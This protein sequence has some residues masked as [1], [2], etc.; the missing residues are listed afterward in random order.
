MSESDNTPEEKQSRKKTACKSEPDYVECDA[1]R[2]SP[3]CSPVKVGDHTYDFTGKMV[4]RRHYFKRGE[5]IFK[6]GEKAELI[7]A[8]SA[9]SL[10]LIAHVKD[11]N[12]VIDF[13]IPGE[14]IDVCSLNEGRY[15][16]SAQALED[17]Y[18][19][20]IGKET[21]NDIASQIPEVQGRLMKVVSQELINI[22]KSSMLM[23]GNI[24][25]EEKIAAFILNLAWR[26]QNSGYSS[27]KFKLNMTRTDIA[28]FLG[29]SK[30]SVIRLF[31]KLQQR[32][33]IQFKGKNVNIIDVEALQ[34]FVGI[35]LI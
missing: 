15:A 28:D 1:C 27:R 16:Y 5:M 19:C 13:R 20:E 23:H 9:G 12:R 26:Y 6:Q 22:Q 2:L 29:L 21:L 17:I 4:N 11:S 14:L 24:N 32:K 3:L 8:I 25:S 31:K 7:F 34:N 10:K 33:F 18:L 30:E 35:K